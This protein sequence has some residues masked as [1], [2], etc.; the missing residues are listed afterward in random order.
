MK[1]Q[2]AAKEVYRE[3]LNGLHEKYFKTGALDKGSINPSIFD[4]PAI[5][6]K[7][8]LNSLS[9]RQYHSLNNKKNE[10]V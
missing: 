6:R 2:A 1:K 3:E 10:L 9:N 4:R 5:A 8:S 7:S